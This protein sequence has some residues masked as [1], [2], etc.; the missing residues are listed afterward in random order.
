M[1]EYNTLFLAVYSLPMET[2]TEIAKQI[3]IEWGEVSTGPQSS[4]F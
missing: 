4:V 1:E 3:T 2:N